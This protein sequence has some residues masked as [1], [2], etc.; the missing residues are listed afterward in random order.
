MTGDADIDYYDSGNKTGDAAGNFNLRLSITEND[1]DF[2]GNHVRITLGAHTTQNSTVTGAYI[3]EKAASGDAY[4]MEPGTITEIT[5]DNGNSGCTV[6]A[7]IDK[8]SDWIEY[9]YNEGKNYI[10]TST[11]L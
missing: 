5:F 9:N 3:G 10:S 2:N 7:G 4:D 1:I 8:V 11:I 6:S